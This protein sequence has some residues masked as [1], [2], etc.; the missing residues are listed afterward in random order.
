M[1]D[2]SGTVVWSADY[3]PFGE[4][5]ITVSTITNNLRFPGQYYDAETGL[6]QNWW[7]DYNFSNGRYV[8]SDPIGLLGGS[9]SYAYVA[10]NPL[11]YADPFG[12]Q[13]FGLGIETPKSSAVANGVLNPNDDPG[14]TFA[15]LMNNNGQ[16]TNLLS[17]G[18]ASR[19]GA[20]NKN[21]FLNGTLG[22][23]S[24]W[25]ISGQIST[26]QWN[27]TPQ[28][29]AQCMH[30][31]NQM[32]Q[33]PGNY[34]PSNQC[35]SAAVSLAKKCGI[36]V[37][38]GVSPVNVPAIFPIFNGYSNNLPNPYGLQQQL[39]STMTPSVVPAS[40]VPASFFQ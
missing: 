17:V 2:G 34:S 22:A 32:K 3:K 21:S 24:N 33:N 29:Y 14:H 39:N 26:Y 7:R 18:P 12:L 4:A 15:Y 28:Q 36:N 1:T 20:R 35:T 27:M 31:F 9:N 37:P 40:F 38:S 5:T 8:Q 10:G 23:V 13:Q 16:V 11:G 25:G 19:I 30:A 6:H